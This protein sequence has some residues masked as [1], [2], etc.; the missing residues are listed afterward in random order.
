MWGGGKYTIRVAN[1][2]YEMGCDIARDICMDKG[3]R[4]TRTMSEGYLKV[5]YDGERLVFNVYKFQCIFSNVAVIRDDKCDCFAY[6]AYLFKCQRQL[7]A[8]LCE[9]A[10]WDKQWRWL[11]HFA[12]VFSGEHE[13]DAW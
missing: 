9:G 11:K 6:I 4:V 10:M 1:A 12:Q 5:M 8:R 13:V 2:L 3:C 7:C